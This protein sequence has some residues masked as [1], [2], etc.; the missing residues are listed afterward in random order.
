MNRKRIAAFAVA[1]LAV[2]PIVACST[3]VP[4]GVTAVKVEDYAFI[5]TDPTVEGCIKP[6][7]NEYNPIG[8]FKAYMYPARQISYDALDAPDAEAPATVV[9]SN[10][11]APAELKV[12][13]TVTFDLTQDCEQLK[14]FHRDFG[15]KYQGWLNDDG[16]VS[17]GWKDLLNYVV[18]QPLQ[19][20]LVSIAQKYEWRKIW[21]DEAVRV[22]FQNALRETLP[23]VSRDRTDGVDYFTN[24][25]VTVMKPDPVD[26]NL[27]SAIIAEQNSIAQARAAEAKGVADANAAKAKAEADVAAA[28][29]Q[30]KVAEQ[31][32]LKRAAEIRGYP[33]VDSYLKAVAIEKGI[34]PWPSPVIAGAPAR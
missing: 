6:E 14:N 17:Q 20:T 30:T 19:N 7:T 4:A 1:A 21:N 25:Q 23:K 31:E 29:A 5:P 24:F 26:A 33:D 9:V 11:S 22:E 13:V 15:T 34:T 32:A 8:G 10:A 28:V 2:L 12:P 16:S 18:G 27:K 3:S